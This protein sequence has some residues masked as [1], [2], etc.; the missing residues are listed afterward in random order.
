MS[1]LTLFEYRVIAADIMSTLSYISEVSD[2]F[3]TWLIVELC[4]MTNLPESETVAV[5]E[6]FYLT[7][8]VRDSSTDSSSRA[9]SFSVSVC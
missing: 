4:F 2:Q 3:R 8:H 9:I 6:I 1:E 7:G 5:Q